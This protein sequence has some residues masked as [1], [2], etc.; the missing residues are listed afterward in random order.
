MILFILVADVLTRYIENNKTIAG[1]KYKN[2]ETK[3]IQHADDTNFFFQNLNSLA[4]ILEELKFYEKVS[5]QNLNQNK[6]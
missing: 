5:G 6:S 3:I 4:L 1:F 2:V